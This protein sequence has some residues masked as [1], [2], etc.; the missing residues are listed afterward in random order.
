MD[1][2]APQSFPSQLLECQAAANRILQVQET[3]GA[4]PWFENGA[5]DPWNH[6]ESAMA[7]TVMGETDA[8]DLAYKYLADTQRLDGAWFGDYGNALPMVGRDYI[9][10]E[11][12]PQMLDTNFC[13]YPAVGI[14]HAYLK[15]G[16]VNWP[17]QYWPMV[18]AAMDFVLS[19]QR[20]DGTI[21]WS[22]EAVGT[23]ED[24]ALLAGNASIAKSLECA[25][26]LARAL[27][28][29]CAN[30]VLAHTRLLSA[31]RSQ[32]GAFDRRGTGAR[33]AMDWYYPILS[34]A[35]SRE[36]SEARLAAG[37]KT[38]V[39]EDMGCRCVTDEPWITVAET[40]E[41]VITLV[42]LGKRDLAQRMLDQVANIHDR[43]G[44]FWM[45][46][47]FAENLYWP[48]EKPSWTQAAYILAKDA[49]FG[50]DASSRL[51]THSLLETP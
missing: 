8:A 25:I 6:T 22:L 12:A 35:L 51:L 44:V 7:L 39:A 11:A 1:D 17:R 24:D 50:T 28:E 43:D 18:K 40:S 38:Y 5:W 45:G 15:S 32:P 3:S 14:T 30:W 36:T 13:A 26:F 27:S 16:D 46:W 47:Q 19:L 33:F 4:I 23:D 29:P 48:K 9:S 10:R 42:S 21:S 37:W 49:L 34:G 2:L 20:S 41:L 31:L